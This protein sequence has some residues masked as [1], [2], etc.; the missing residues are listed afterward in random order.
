MG[1]V[2]G[3]A[4]FDDDTAAD[5]RGIYRAYIEQGVDDQEAFQRILK[6][7]QKWFNR[8][9]GVG[10]LVGFAVTQSELGQLDPAI[11]DQA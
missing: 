11:R 1:V 4:L 9:A 3:P 8:E 7:Y 5:V 10:A 2:S 6:W